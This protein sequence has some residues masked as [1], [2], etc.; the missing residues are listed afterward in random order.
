MK[1]GIPGEITNAITMLYTNTQSMVRSPDGNTY[2]FKITA[3]VLQCDTLAP[4]LFIVC[5]D[6]V[7]KKLL[8]IN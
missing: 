4:F 5:L 2:F 7:L 8:D 3:G 6:Y 1:Y